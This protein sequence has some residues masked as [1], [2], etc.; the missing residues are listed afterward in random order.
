MRDIDA[1]HVTG[2][3]I[4]VDFQ[5]EEGAN[6]PFTPVVRDVEVVNLKCRKAG[7][8]LSLRGYQNAPVRD[9]APSMHLRISG[10]A[11]RHRKRRRARARRRQDRMRHGRPFISRPRSPGRP[12]PPA[13]SARAHREGT[14]SEETRH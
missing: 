14:A 12:G 1:G 5:Y 11:E 6:G 9:P 13:P 7:A 10:K 2:P 4:D 8:A 3:A